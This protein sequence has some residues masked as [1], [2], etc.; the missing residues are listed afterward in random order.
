MTIIVSQFCQEQGAL[1]EFMVWKLGLIENLKWYLKCQFYFEF[2]ILWLIGKKIINSCK[3]V[4]V[5]SSL[6]IGIPW[7]FWMFEVRFEMSNLFRIQYIFIHWKEFINPSNFFLFNWKLNWILTIQ[8]RSPVDEGDLGH[9]R[10]IRMIW[11][12]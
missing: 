8:G 5:Q 2:D 1:K 3:G 10:L 7:E 11:G 4:L 6:G 9:P 12:I